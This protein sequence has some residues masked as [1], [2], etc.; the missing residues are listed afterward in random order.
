MPRSFLVKKMKLPDMGDKPRWA[1]ENDGGPDSPS[2]GATAPQHALFGNGYYSELE[3]LAGELLAR[4]AG[5]EDVLLALTVV[6]RCRPLSR[7]RD[8]DRNLPSK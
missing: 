5:V 2:E 1:I 3:K 8:G 4:T 6:D 7:V